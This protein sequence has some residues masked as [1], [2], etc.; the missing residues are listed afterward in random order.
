MVSMSEVKAFV[1]AAPRVAKVGLSP[2]PCG[3]DDGKRPLVKRWQESG[4]KPD[5]RFIER[6]AKAHPN[7]NLGISCGPSGL[8]VVDVD[9]PKL[10]DAARDR[11]GVT[12]I[13]IATPSSGFHLYYRRG[14]SS[15]RSRNLRRNA[16]LA[17]DIRAEGGLIVAPPS[18]NPQRGKQYSFLSGS[19]DQ[20][21]DLPIFDPDSLVSG[22]ASLPELR[23]PNSSNIAAPST[24]V[25]RGSRNDTLFRVLLRA[26]PDHSSF[27]SLLQAAKALNH[28]LLEPPLSFGEVEQTTRS[29][30]RYETS[31]RNWA[32]GSHGTLIRL[33]ELFSY[34]S[35]QRGG[36]ALIL[37]LYLEQTHMG[38]SDPIAVDR[39]A[40]AR[41]NLL[42][43]WTAWRY[44][45]AREVLIELGVLTPAGDA[46]AVSKKTGRARL[47]YLR[48]QLARARHNITN[49]LVRGADD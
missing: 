9:D 43:N 1:D 16:G 32:G 19:W 48:S 7:A 42:P 44:R 26:A 5:F 31:G 11:F 2:V 35:H 4:Y 33:D 39:E 10:L 8:V 18:I 13:T 24:R 41:A 49:T 27:E 6:M 21:P 28:Q 12:P 30:W 34:A 23:M 38:R 40:M 20:I 17:I 29:V 3:G 45:K 15:V 37:K 25:Q 36:D 14:S 22:S 47:Y 46:N